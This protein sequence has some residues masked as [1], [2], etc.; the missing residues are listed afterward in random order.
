MLSKAL[1]SGYNA[2]TMSPHPQADDPTGL[3]DHDSVELLHL[4]ANDTNN[5]ALWTELLRR[6]TP[7][8]K[9]F[10][11]G[12]LR[13]SARGFALFPDAPLFAG[14]VQETDLFQNTILRLLEKD[15]AAMKRFTGGTGE[16]LLAYLA[17]ITRSV[18][19]DSN[20]R[21]RASK[22]PSA[23]VSLTPDSLKRIQS[24]GLYGPGESHEMERK[25][26][27]RELK[28][29][30]IRTIR[31]LSGP[32][33]SRDQL[34]F[35]LYFDHGLSTTQ[36]ARCEGIELS[37]TGVEKVLTRLKDRVRSVTEV[38]SAEASMR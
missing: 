20:R 13:Q 28:D 17:V 18:V 26:L 24:T 19:R 10:I 16:E 22:R 36:I 37:K 30:S 32:F 8:I 29:L 7:K 35:E 4:C 15:C 14:G 11:R 31:N 9:A 25:I 21:Q 3:R 1:G 34:I 33:S 38:T 23:Q 5:S 27:G 12:T 2:E 6:I